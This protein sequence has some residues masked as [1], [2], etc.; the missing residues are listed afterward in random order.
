MPHKSNGTE[1]GRPHPAKRVTKP[2]KNAGGRAAAGRK[3][4]AVATEV[5]AVVG[6]PAVPPEPSA[7]VAVVRRDVEG[8][9]GQVEAVSQRVAVV[10]QEASR[11]AAMLKEMD[12][13]I[14]TATRAVEKARHATAEAEAAA[15]RAREQAD[16]ARGAAG[17]PAGVEVVEPLPVAAVPAT[18]Q[19]PPLPV[20]A[21]WE[22]PEVEAIPAD[23]VIPDARDRLIRYLNDAA[24]IEREQLGLLQ[25]LSEATTDPGL[26]ADFERF[27]AEGEAH[28]GEVEERVRALG[29][30]PSGGRG[31]F[32]QI[33]TRVWDVLQKP[34]DG[35]PDPVADL[36]KALSAV[37]FGAGMYRA[38]HALARATGDDVTAA[39]AAGHHRQ[40]RQFAER[41]RSL[42]APTAAHTARRLQDQP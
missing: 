39:L 32:G 33:A 13:L 1:S 40:E 31:V 16:A 4:P 2:R 19:P 17:D 36:L 22:L 8:M 37:E 12:E 20:E 35:G 29:G 28:R 5:V 26:L 41:L 42:V 27:R 25:A 21:T 14:E 11:T 9:K 3:K 18:E 15:R 38:V 30:E 7:D 10:K 34:R 6:T 24:A 23:D